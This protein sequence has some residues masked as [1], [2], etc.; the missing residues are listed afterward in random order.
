MATRAELTNAA[1][2]T[3]ACD[4]CKWKLSRP[5]SDYRAYQRMQEHEK[6]HRAGRPPEEGDRG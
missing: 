3:A 2:F 5:V 1:K 4:R 6:S